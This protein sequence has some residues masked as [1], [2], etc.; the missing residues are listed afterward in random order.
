MFSGDVLVEI[1]PVGYELEIHEEKAA[2]LRRFSKVKTPWK[3][4]ECLALTFF[5]FFKN[6]LIV[7]FI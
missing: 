5:S 4:Y 7:D 1:E 2:D 6:M 3:I